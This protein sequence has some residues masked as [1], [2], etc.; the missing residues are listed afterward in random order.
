MPKLNDTALLG[1]KMYSMPHHLKMSY[2]GPG[3]NS[4]VMQGASY[5]NVMY[6]NDHVLIFVKQI[7]PEILKT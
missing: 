7:D 6:T 5:I 3:S 1:C 2:F 4:C